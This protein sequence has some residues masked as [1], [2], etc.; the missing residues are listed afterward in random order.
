MQFFHS[1][2]HFFLHTH[3]LAQAYHF[4]FR[5]VKPG[6]GSARVG[7]VQRLNVFS[8]SSSAL[9]VCLSAALWSVEP[10]RP[11]VFVY[12]QETPA[13][14]LDK[15]NAFRDAGHYEQA[16]STYAEARRRYQ[17]QADSQGQAHVL[18]A[19][20]ALEQGQGQV[21][22]AREAYSQAEAL[23]KR[24]QDRLGQAHVL[25]G[26]GNLEREAADPEKAQGAYAHAYKL[27]QL[28]R[29]PIGQAHVLLGMGHVERRRGKTDQAHNFL[30]RALTLY[31]EQGDYLGRAQAFFALGQL[32]TTSDPLVAQRY[33]EQAAEQY[34]ASGRIARATRAEDRALRLKDRA[35]AASPNGAPK[36]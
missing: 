5:P 30:F 13:A 14:V 15:A 28:E 17:Q 35:Q 23:Y 34:R 24:S 6:R 3:D 18:L 12:A 4:H 2:P 25:L 36:Q 10:H 26:L 9:L 21:L 27:Y 22:Q 8:L 33:Y 20:G 16:R 1:V 19:L 7:G 29:D 11:T 31:T 32:Y